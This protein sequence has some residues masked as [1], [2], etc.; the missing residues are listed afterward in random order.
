MGGWDE[1][2]H[3]TVQGLPQRA[4]GKEPAR[5]RGRHGTLGSHPWV[6]KTPCRRRQPTPVFL[7]GE[8]WW[9]IVHRATKSQTQLKLLGTII[10]IK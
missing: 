4:S 6:G 3:G 9:A 1:R 5:Q 7:P 10:L 2:L 8:A